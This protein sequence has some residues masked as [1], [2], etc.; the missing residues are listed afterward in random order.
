MMKMRNLALIILLF[1]FIIPSV[2]QLGSNHTSTDIELSKTYTESYVHHDAIW[3][4]SDAEFH[5]QATLESWDGEGTE[6]SPY[7]ITGYLFDCETQPLRIWHTTIHWIFTGNEIFGVGSNIQCGTW[8]ENVTNGAIVDNE[9]HNRHSG[10][11]IAEVENFV[12]SD[13][14]IHDCWGR[15]IEF[16]GAMNSTIINDNVLENIGQEGI[17]SVASR[18]CIIT[19]NTI[20]GCAQGGIT[21]IGQ[22]P[23][24]TISQNEVSDCEGSGILI[25][26]LTDG[27]VNDNIITLV[28]SHGIYLSGLINCESSGNIVTDAVRSGMKIAAAQF[29]DISEN[30]IDNCNEDGLLLTSGTNT[31]VEWN[32]VSNVT[33]YGINLGSSSTFFS[34]RYNAFINTSATSQVNDDGTSNLISH[35]Y[36]DDWNYPD[37]D[38]NGYVDSPY[39]FDGEAANQDEFPLAIMGVIP[40][41]ESQSSTTNSSSNPLPMDLILIAGGIGAIIIIAALLMIKRR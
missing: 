2:Q 34:V 14:Y 9:V 24:C 13:N 12:V 39:V 5:S 22:T 28:G 31:T 38:G 36:Y 25:S 3:I 32:S 23:K 4:Q 10:L 35:N 20:S 40:S 26:G 15:G 7:V 27:E 6:E 29:C 41:T 18:D 11:A 21:L 8:I 16:F 37:T 1:M 19:H 30:T 17:Y 33:G